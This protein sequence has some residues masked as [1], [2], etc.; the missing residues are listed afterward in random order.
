[1]RYIET[2]GNMSEAVVHN[3]LIYLSGQIAEDLDDDFTAQC[4]SVFNVVDN[5]L[6]RCG[7]G[8][9]RLLSVTIFLKDMGCYDVFN[10]CW[11]SWLGKTTPPSR[12]CLQAGLVLPDALVELTVVAAVNMSVGQGD[13]R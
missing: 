4:E 6:K 9:D 11:R 7:S 3:G 8:K 1:M 12:T 10:A 13:D 5:L 2:S